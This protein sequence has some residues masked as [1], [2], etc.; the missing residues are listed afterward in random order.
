MFKQE[1]WR[2]KQE[3]NRNMS[4]QTSLEE[5]RRLW[6]E[7]Q[8]RERANIEK[9]RVCFVTFYCL[10]YHWKINLHAVNRLCH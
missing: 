1:R 2:M 10:H 5:E 9:T 4:Q 3:Q 7:Q 8:A 6:T